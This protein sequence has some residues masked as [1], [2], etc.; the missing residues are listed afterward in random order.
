MS[1]KSIEHEGFTVTYEPKELVCDEHFFKVE[2]FA[3]LMPD[4]LSTPEEIEKLANQF[5][6]SLLVNHKKEEETG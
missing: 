5:S 3:Y 1:L 6:F 4:G 2:E